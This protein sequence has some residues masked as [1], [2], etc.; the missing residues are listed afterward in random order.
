[1]YYGLKRNYNYKLLTFLQP[2]VPTYVHTY[3]FVW[4]GASTYKQADTHTYKHITL[5]TWISSCIDSL[6][7]FLFLHIWWV[8]WY[9]NL[10]RLLIILFT[11]SCRNDFLDNVNNTSL[12]ILTKKSSSHSFGT[13]DTTSKK[14]SELFMVSISS[15]LQ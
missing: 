10:S 8:I 1:M 14:C 7:N 12:I 15:S 4:M 13:F 2:T 6:E 9:K 11:I 5:H 3:I